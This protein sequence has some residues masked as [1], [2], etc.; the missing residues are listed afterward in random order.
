YPS[1]SSAVSTAARVASEMPGR[2]LSTRLTVA[3]LT[4]TYFATSASLRVTV[5][6]IVHNRASHLHW[7]GDSWALNGVVVATTSSG[8]LDRPIHSGQFVPG[9][10]REP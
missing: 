9:A 1:T 6:S 8:S 7:M 5:A 3:S 2:P 4:P 10:G